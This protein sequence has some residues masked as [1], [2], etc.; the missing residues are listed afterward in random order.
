[1]DKTASKADILYNEVHKVV[2]ELAQRES[3]I[4]IGQCADYILRKHQPCFRVFVHALMEDELNAL[5]EITV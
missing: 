5:L 3:C 1:M 4:I 2:T